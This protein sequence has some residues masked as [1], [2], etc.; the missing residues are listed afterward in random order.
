MIK[1]LLAG[2]GLAV[3]AA[4]AAFAQPS[5]TVQP[6][7]GN[8]PRDGIQTR[9]EVVERV[10]DRFARMD[11]NRDG[12]LTRDEAQ[13]ARGQMRGQRMGR[14]GQ[15]Q[16]D[17]ARR[18]ERQ[19]RA[20]DRFDLDRNGVI[21]RDEFAQVRTTRGDRGQRAGMHRGMRMG[22][23]MGGQMFA[24]ADL[25]RDNRVSMQEATQAAVRHFDMVDANRDGRITREEREQMRQRMMGQRGVRG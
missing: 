12:F 6:Q 7:F 23:R 9:N 15:R 18:A 3:L 25:N 19:A 8:A 22:G 13:A 21:S 17:P 5:S 24:M 10:R 14:N 4:T 1:S 16:I 2:A 20:F 11:L